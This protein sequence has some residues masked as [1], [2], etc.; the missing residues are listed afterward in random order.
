MLSGQRSVEG[1]RL[2]A[3]ELTEAQ[4][5]LRVYLTAGGLALLGVLLTLYTIWWWRGTRPEPPALGPLEVMSD[6]RWD[7]AGEPDRRRWVDGHRPAG[8]LALDGHVAGPEPIDLSVL[9][10]SS[11]DDFGDLREPEPV[12]LSELV[13]RAAAPE[14]LD[15]PDHVPGDWHAEVAAFG[16]ADAD[17]DSDEREGTSIDPLLQRAAS[18]D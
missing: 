2:V 16:R 11:V 1:A 3:A 17:A 12:D 18:S 14:P 10:R 13:A 9:A 8:A 6:R 7:K 5:S 15:E 4:A